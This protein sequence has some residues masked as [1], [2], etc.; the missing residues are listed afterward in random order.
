VRIAIQGGLAYEWHRLS[1]NRWY[2]D[3][4]NAQLALPTQEQAVPS[5]SLL[6]VRARQTATTPVPTV[7]IALTLSSQRQV[8]IVP[9]DGGLTLAVNPVD[10]VSGLRTGTGQFGTAPAALPPVEAAPPDETPA[11]LET[12]WKFA[13]TLNPKLIVIDPGHGGS[14]TG[15]AHNGLT[16]KDVTLDISMRLRALLLARGWQVK[17]TRSDDSD[18]YAPNDS[19]RDELQ[20][21]DD[22]ANNAGAR[23]LVSVHVNSFTS[24]GLAGTTTYYFKSG[25]LSLA[26]AIHRRLIASLGTKDD[27][28]RKENFYV[29]HHARMPAVLVETAFLSNPDDAALLH[30]PAFLQKVATSIADG[31]G[32]Y[33]SGTTPPQTDGT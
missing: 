14:D 22:V 15:A 16:E 4:Q 7:R 6:S 17:L 33:A 30:S 2:V 24:S 31:I 12:P 8:D 32:D 19:A 13:P 18:V 3:L 23:M 27:G 9:N 28:V 21:R 20:A 5:G 10:D 1:D 11:P 29:L 26:E 25:D